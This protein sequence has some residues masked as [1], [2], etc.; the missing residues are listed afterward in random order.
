LDLILKESESRPNINFNYFCNYEGGG[1]DDFQQGI[2]QFSLD[3]VVKQAKHCGGKGVVGNVQAKSLST[4]IADLRFKNFPQL[5]IVNPQR[6][7]QSEQST[8]ASFQEL[9][10]NKVI[11]PDQQEVSYT[12]IAFTL[13]S[14]KRCGRGHFTVYCKK[15]DTVWY[16]FD[17]DRTTRK[18]KNI[19]MKYNTENILARVT[20]LY[21]LKNEEA[22]DCEV[23]EEEENQIRTEKSTSTA[24]AVNDLAHSQTRGGEVEE[25]DSQTRDCEVEEEEENQIRTEKSTLTASDVNDLTHSQTR[26]GEVEEEVENRMRTDKPTSTASETNNGAYIFIFCTA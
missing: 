7:T 22:R 6:Q 19:A 8:H 3:L 4:Y 24:S 14:E 9:H 16:L 20:S 23:E 25:E 10:F 26:G 11:T 2:L 17:D 15:G 13:F 21:Y 18:G 12:L 5:L 1:I